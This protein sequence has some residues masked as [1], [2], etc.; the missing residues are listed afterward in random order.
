M[1]VMNVLPRHPGSA[2][3]SYVFRHSALRERMKRLHTIRPCHLLGDSGYPEEPWL[4]TPFHG[5]ATPIERS[6]QEHYNYCHCSD[7][8]V[9][10]RSIGLMK[11][12]WRV[13][14]NHRILRYFPDR[15]RHLCVAVCILHNIC[16]LANHHTYVQNHERMVN[17]FFNPRVVN[18]QNEAGVHRAGELVREAI[19]EHLQRR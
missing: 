19:V 2:P 17:R 1:F 13:I 6:P 18:V 3:D 7:R 15:V 10:E 14:N 12:R 11:E 4:T 5:N 16:I 8:N 9:V